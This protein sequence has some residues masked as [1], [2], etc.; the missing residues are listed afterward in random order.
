MSDLEF[1][2]KTKL[3]KLFGMDSGYVLNFSNRTFA[4][5]VVGS[6]GKDIYDERYTYGSGSKANRLRA[7]WDLESNYLTAKLTSDML[8]YCRDSSD[9]VQNLWN[10][11]HQ[12][13]DRLRKMMPVPDVDA[14]IV[15]ETN[16]DFL[17][18]TIR[19][20]IEQHKPESGLDRLHTYVTKR[21]RGLCE[22]QG[23]NVSNDKPLHSLIGEY[24]KSLRRDGLVESEMTDLILKSSISIMDRFND[25][26]NNWS[27]A[28]DNPLLS[29][30]ESLLILNY[31][32]NF[33]NFVSA[34]EQE[35]K[36]RVA[37]QDAAASIDDDLPF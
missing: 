25:V 5:F 14:L 37:K 13:V 1:I 8:E 22:E 9:G 12:I 31:M 6:T 28:H 4:A 11:C 32:T 2:E 3:E 21:I 35:R 23:I 29:K 16:L 33:L 17:A 18:E 34:I 10:D 24:I 7:F 19:S 36:S 27:L 26:R 20:A 30:H 15:G